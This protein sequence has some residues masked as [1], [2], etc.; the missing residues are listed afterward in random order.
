[1]PDRSRRRSIPAADKNVIAVTATNS[2]DQLLAEANRGRHIAVAAPGVDVIVPAPG[3]GYQ[4][5]TGT[6]V[7]AAEVSGIVALLIE[8]QPGLTPDEIRKILQSTA[9]D[10]GPKGID[11]QF[12]AGLADARRAV[13]SLGVG[14]AAAVNEARASAAG[15]FAERWPEMPLMPFP[16]RR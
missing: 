1:M 13:L 8:L 6:S 10:L 7:A 11:E 9:L 2:K 14:E 16:T 12:G 4:L 15:L 3:Q 5:S